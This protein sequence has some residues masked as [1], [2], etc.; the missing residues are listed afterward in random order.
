MLNTTRT[1]E[2]T[3]SLSTLFAEP[4]QAGSLLVDPACD[5]DCIALASPMTDKNGDP[6]PN[7]CMIRKCKRLE[8]ANPFKQNDGS[9]S[10][11]SDETTDGS[12]SKYCPNVA[13]PAVYVPV[14]DENGVTY[15]NECAMKAAKCKGKKLSVMEEY[16]PEHA[17]GARNA[18]EDDIGSL[19]EDDSDGVIG[20]DSSL[21]STK[22]ADACPSVELPVCGSD[23]ITYMNPCKLKVAACKNPEHNIVEDEDDACPKDT[24]G[25]KSSKA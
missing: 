15:T 19:Y 3:E 18:D 21:T 24:F 5:F 10:I 2:P 13:C 25:K 20:D 14:S 7:E 12:D 1:N 16:K 8:G 4:N 22:C 6:I 17:T 9:E 11:S 23:G